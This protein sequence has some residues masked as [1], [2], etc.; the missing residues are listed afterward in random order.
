MENYQSYTVKFNEQIDLL[1]PTL[2]IS[3]LLSSFKKCILTAF[4]YSED[5]LMRLILGQQSC[6]GNEWVILS[7]GR[8]PQLQ[9][10]LGVFEHSLMVSI[11][12][13]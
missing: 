8:Y 7:L 12:H 11:M 13:I 3:L 1:S 10:T 2:F 5:R 4:R 9:F 6:L